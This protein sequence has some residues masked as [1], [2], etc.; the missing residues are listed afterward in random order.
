MDETRVY[1]LDEYE[2]T[3]IVGALHTELEFHEHALK[4]G[5]VVGEDADFTR[6]HI[7]QLKRLITKV[8]PEGVL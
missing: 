6:S 3:L 7:A 1:E 2:Q 8:D 4:K 5:E